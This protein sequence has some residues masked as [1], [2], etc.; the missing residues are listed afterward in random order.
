LSPYQPDAVSGVRLV[1]GEMLQ[2]SDL[3][4]GVTPGVATV[5]LHA[6]W[7]QS[8]PRHVLAVG[9]RAASWVEA[10]P[11][12]ADV[13]VLV[14][15]LPDARAL[16]AVSGLRPA[17]TVYC[18]SLD[19]F[20]PQQAYDLIVALDG[21]VRL[22]SPDSE[23]IG[24]RETLQ[25]LAKWLGPEGT[26]VAV[27][28][29]DL[30]FDNLLRV[31]TRN[32]DSSDSAWDLGASG[33]DERPLYYREVNDVLAAAD[34]AAL[35]VYAVFPSAENVA[36]LVGR[37]C[38]EERALA[39]TAAAL[40]ARIEARHFAQR[41]ALV[42]AADLALRLFEAHQVMPLAAGWLVV[43]RPSAAEGST[44]VELPALLA[45]EEITRPEWR[46]Q[47]SVQRVDGEWAHRLYPAINASEMREGHMVRD[48]RA[49]DTTVLPGPTLEAA[50]RRACATYDVARVRTLV[51][52]Y[53]GWLWSHVG[54]VDEGDPRF[55]AVPANVVLTT[56]GCAVFDPT[57]RWTQ[58]LP[59]D[60]L[61]VRGLR[62]FSRRLLRSG[63]EHPWAPDVNPDRLTQTLAAMAGVDV[64]AK[65][66]DQVAR[67]EAEIEVVLGGGDAVSES[68]AYAQNLDAGRSQFSSQSGA[69]RGYREALAVSGRLAQALGDR[70]DQVEWLQLTVRAR[71]R[72]LGDL[73]RRQES[74]RESVSFKI[75]RALTWP[76]RSLVLLARRV[77][78]SAI[79]PGYITKAM[80]LLR[81]F[82][83][84]T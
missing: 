31:Q 15:A 64:S 81:R 72:Q 22:V 11:V 48:Y 78:V 13:D 16:S 5:L 33:F 56:D 38:V 47:R 34:L 3:G 39:Q 41:P 84:R 8:P 25:R 36:L 14:R 7:R 74:L 12:G 73:E 59:D 51:Q 40:A 1:G 6:L 75:G 68:V 54:T 45:G 18:G 69:S 80:N 20:E 53:S 4:Q 44:S 65:A 2:W 79:P 19:R 82:A 29:N 58:R 49:L 9:P 30:G 26:L 67:L 52:Q 23:G 71:D 42:D 62:D 61:L 77:A 76:A 83:D 43:S 37:D 27:L 46:V 10:T 21:P 50:L 24:H 70:S 35:S 17:V 57:W 32:R 63:A 66:I 60:V 55:F 28:E